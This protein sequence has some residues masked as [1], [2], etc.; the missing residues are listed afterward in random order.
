MPALDDLNPASDTNLA[1]QRTAMAAE[2]TLMAWIRTALAMISFGF[3]IGKLGD[4]LSSAK[5]NLFGRTTDIVGLAYF[6]VVVGTVALV[7]AVIQNRIEMAQLFPPGVKRKPSVAFAV[8]V[9]LSLLGV[10]VFADL[11]T[12]F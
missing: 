1:T 5:V 11:V 2:R 12:R 10:F 6:L 9:L 3:T 4:A 7:L 8:A